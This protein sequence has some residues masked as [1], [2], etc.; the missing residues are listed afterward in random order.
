MRE[1]ASGLL[2]RLSAS[3]ERNCAAL[4]IVILLS[5]APACSPDP[6]ND[7]QPSKVL[8]PCR[9]SIAP[10]HPAGSPPQPHN[11][12]Q[13]TSLFRATGSCGEGD[14]ESLNVQLLALTRTDFARAAK[15]YAKCTS[16]TSDLPS[17]SQSFP[18]T[19]LAR[20][21]TNPS[22]EAS[23]IPGL[24][25]LRNQITRNQAIL[26]PK[27]TE[28][29]PF[30]DIAPE[31]S[32]IVTATFESRVN[33]GILLALTK[34]VS[35]RFNQ[36]QTLVCVYAES[37]YRDLSGDVSVIYKPNDAVTDCVK[38]HLASRKRHG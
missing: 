12:P 1:A 34:P 26:S 11:V 37:G 3:I 21:A 32:S 9:L 14:S 28:Y 31:V 8:N 15:A 4:G 20:L 13:D 17:L 36:E 30:D 29:S 6:G 23:E 35:Q 27:T 25:N 18:R 2:P 16:G 22:C 24:L 19:L 10:A 5:V 38:E 33:S 7:R